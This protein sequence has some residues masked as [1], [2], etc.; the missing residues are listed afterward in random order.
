MSGRWER[1]TVAIGNGISDTGA[2]LILQDSNL[3]IQI[4]FTLAGVSA[5]DRAAPAIR[6]VTESVLSLSEV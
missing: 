6:N 2:A 3:A 5:N 4:H 1:A